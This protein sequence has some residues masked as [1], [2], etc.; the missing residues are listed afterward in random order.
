MTKA[1]LQKLLPKVDL[2]GHEE[3]F[4]LGTDPDIL[5]PDLTDRWLPS[6]QGSLPRVCA[7]CAQPIAVHTRVEL[8]CP[9]TP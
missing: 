4:T 9:N 3:P 5:F 2:D 8:F 7:H 1:E 6:H